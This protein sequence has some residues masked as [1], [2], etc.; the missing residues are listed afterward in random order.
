[1]LAGIGIWE[2]VMAK[3][4]FTSW[5]DTTEQ[6]VLA[7]ACRVTKVVAYPH[8]SQ[9]AEVYIQFWDA[10]NPTPGT[11]DTKMCLPIG[12][13]TVNGSRPVTFLFPNGGIRFA[14]AC[15]IFCATGAEGATAPTTTSLPPQIDVYYL[16]GN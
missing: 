13:K 16:T 12:S 3:K 2:D 5:A 4:S 10:A 6:T 7:A 14:T 11:D 1:M 8:E 9:A 15:T